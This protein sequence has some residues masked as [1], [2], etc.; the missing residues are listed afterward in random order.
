[1]AT[2]WSFTTSRRQLS[3]V[4]ASR[5]THDL[6]QSYGTRPSSIILYRL[7]Y[8]MQ[9][10]LA[11]NEGD[12]RQCYCPYVYALDSSFFLTKGEI[13]FIHLAVFVGER[14]RFRPHFKYAW[15][16][17]LNQSRQKTN[18]FLPLLFSVERWTK[19]VLA[20]LRRST[21]SWLCRSNPRTLYCVFPTLMAT[22][23]AFL[24]T[25]LEVQQNFL[26]E[27]AFVLCIK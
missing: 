1:M 12:D 3:H 26:R 25:C 10:T 6:S 17:T 24:P 9:T 4:S 13:I 16:L 2:V 5:Y 22:R 27:T 20:C 11:S 7:P 15:T 8:S 19:T 23:Q 14:W 21:S 18:Y